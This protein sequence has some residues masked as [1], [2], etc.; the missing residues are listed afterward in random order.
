MCSDVLHVL[1]K[2]CVYKFIVYQ[3]QF[4]M[5]F[6]R[7]CTPFASCPDDLEHKF[8]S[9]I[10]F[11]RATYGAD[12]QGSV[13][14]EGLQHWNFRHL[15]TILDETLGEEHPGV[16]IPGVNTGAH[17]FEKCMQV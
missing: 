15:R 5:V 12:V 6:C 7:Y 2:I 1:H 17:S 16:E 11:I 10:T 3:F 13:S 4:A 14:D 9:N 8:W